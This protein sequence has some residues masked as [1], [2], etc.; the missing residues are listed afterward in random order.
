MQRSNT[1]DLP[2][3]FTR[4]IAGMFG[5]EG[6]K[7]LAELPR[8]IAAV[9]ADWSLKTGKPLKN[10]SYHYVAPC[11]C[12]DGTEAILKIGFPE[13]KTE[14]FSETETLK[15]YNGDGAARLLRADEKRYAMLLEKLVPGKTLGEMCLKDDKET[16]R[17]AAGTLKKI[18]RDVPK[19]G[20]FHKLDDW[21]GGFH[22]AKDT[23][24]PADVI[25]K[26]QSFYKELTGKNKNFLLHGDFHHENILS[27]TREPFL[28]IDPKGLIGGK[29]YDIGVFLNNHRNWLEGT[30]GFKEKLDRAVAQFSHVFEIESSDI[31]K[32]AFVQAILS[33]WWTF[34]ENN[35]NWKAEIN[36]AGVWQV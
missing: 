4:T 10:L 31:G 3:K 12:A 6:T 22:R 36:K 29:G 34:E 14:F 8:I 35:E 20:D 2:Q 5:E 16:V 9:S 32:W 24:F 33:A 15:L 7:W 11:I 21:I 25:K 26:A 27:S 17:I 30:P 28:V 19:G 13:E 23:E 1:F 18:I